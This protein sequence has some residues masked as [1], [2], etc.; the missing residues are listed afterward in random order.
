[1]TSTLININMINEKVMASETHAAQEALNDASKTY[2]DA[3]QERLLHSDW[4]IIVDK[5]N[6]DNYKRASVKDRDNFFGRGVKRYRTGTTFATLGGQYSSLP[7]PNMHNVLT[8][9]H[10][11]NTVVDDTDLDGIMERAAAE[12]QELQAMIDF[13]TRAK[14]D[15]QGL[16]DDWKSFRNELIIVKRPMYSHE[17]AIYRRKDGTRVAQT[18]RN[19]RTKRKK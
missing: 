19:K 13:V 18:K 15:I 6:L 14:A 12:M 7:Q 16:Y 11:A 10:P 4:D 1:M 9:I 3:L 17:G 5:Q 2:S 8:Y